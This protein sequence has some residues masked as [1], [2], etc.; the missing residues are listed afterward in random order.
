MK[1]LEQF[2]VI[3]RL[4][5]GRLAT[6]VSRGFLGP[7]WGQFGVPEERLLGP[8]PGD[9]ADLAAGAEWRALRLRRRVLAGARRQARARAGAALAAVGRRQ[10]GAG[11]DPA[12]GRVRRGLDRR[13]DAALARR[14]GR[15]R[16]PLSGAR[17]ASWASARSSCACRTAGS[18]TRARRRCAS[19]ARTTR[20]WSTSTPARTWAA[21]SAPPTPPT[22]CSRHPR[23]LHLAAGGTARG[24]G[25][26]LRRLLLPRLHRPV[27]GGRARADRALR[28]AGRRAD[29][30]PL[31]GPG[32][33]GHPTAL[34]IA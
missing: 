26:R 14:L 16:G 22:T 34:P 29:P 32:P 9:A 5:G 11:G 25:H 33:P 28:R 6:T 27:P 13:P 24:L 1:A 19:S 18:P 2:A 10:R 15:V 30:R 21:T 17:A 7:F 31:P 23:R 4:S 3:D 8:L 20:A 12:L